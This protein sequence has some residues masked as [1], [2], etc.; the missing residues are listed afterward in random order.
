MKIVLDT[1]VL[2]AATFW[3]GASAK[4]MEMIEQKKIRGYVS[5]EILNEYA[6]SIQKK[7]L[8]IKKKEL[9]ILLSY[10][11]LASITEK[12][13]PEVRYKVVLADPDDDKIIECAKAADADCILSYDHH[14][15]DLKVI[16]GVPVL[17]PEQFLSM[18]AGK[19]KGI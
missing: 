18:Q 2:I 8:Q 13:N 1:N 7:R 5:E 14:L 3:E 12:I 19:P 15:L 9:G 10:A 17:T 6:N 16:L 11:K 4:V